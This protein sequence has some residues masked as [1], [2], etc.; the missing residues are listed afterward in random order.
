MPKQKEQETRN[1]H[2]T[3]QRL[4]E[5]GF[6]VIP[7]VEEEKIPEKMDA[8]REAVEQGGGVIAAEQ[9]PVHRTLAYPIEY[10]KTKKKGMFAEGYFGWVKFEAQSDSVRE[11]KK[12]LEK[13]RDVLRFLI[14]KV[15]DATHPVIPK[16]A[17]PAGV[18]P[19]RS[20][21]LRGEPTQPPREEIS[22]EALDEAIKELVV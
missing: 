20:S 2:G 19:K 12:S 7:T 10:V 1:Q 8:V 11:V 14:T 22:D 21:S 15:P 18:S 13:N 6:L 16:K 5:V 17:S 3:E 4:Y 9:R